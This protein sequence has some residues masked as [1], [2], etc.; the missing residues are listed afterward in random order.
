MASLDNIGAS[1]D[2]IEASLQECCIADGP[3]VG[4]LEVGGE[5]R[6]GDEGLFEGG[7]FFEE[8]AGTIGIEF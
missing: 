2:N 1:L 6:G 4:G 8:R 3:G 7:D 5:M